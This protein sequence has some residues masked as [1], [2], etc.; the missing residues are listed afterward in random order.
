MKAKGV[1]ASDLAAAI[2]GRSTDSR[3]YSVARNRDR[4]GHYTAGTSYPAPENLAKIAEVLN[5]PVEDLNPLPPAPPVGTVIQGGGNPGPRARAL[6][7]AVTVSTV[8]KGR[9]RLQVDK[10]VSSELALRIAAMIEA[11]DTPEIANMGPE[12]GSIING[13][14]D[15]GNGNNGDPRSALGG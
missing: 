6:P 3:G 9:M 2:W 13:G 15:N 4:I 5:V 8:E 14:K 7:A 12:I 11:T 10:V 1:S